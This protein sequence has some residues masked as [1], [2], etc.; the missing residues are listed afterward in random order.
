MIK[1][2]KISTSKRSERAEIYIPFPLETAKNCRK[3][4]NDWK[5]YPLRKYYIYIF[6]RTAGIFPSIEQRKRVKEIFDFSPINFLEKWRKSET[7]WNFKRRF[8]I[9]S[10]ASLANLYYFVL[11]RGNLLGAIYFFCYKLNF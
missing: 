3:P 7:S 1:S 10:C 9:F 2:S 11:K 8:F 4:Q 5:Q 6:S